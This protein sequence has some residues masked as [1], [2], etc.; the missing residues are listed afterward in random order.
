MKE[1]E[2]LAGMKQRLIS[3]LTKCEDKVD[4]FSFRDVVIDPVQPNYFKIWP[5]IKIGSQDFITL[6][7]FHFLKGFREENIFPIV[8]NTAFEFKE[9]ISK[10]MQEI[11]KEINK[12]TVIN[13][14]LYKKYL[15]EN[16]E[17]IYN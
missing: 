10:G 4:W 14:F 6:A 2:I 3:A 7:R 8:Q 11:I 1:N 15:E 9:V 5:E 13:R 17:K 16:Q 12:E